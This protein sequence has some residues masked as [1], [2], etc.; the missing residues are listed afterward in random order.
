MR[1][2]NRILHNIL[3]KIL[4]F[5]SVTILSAHENVKM[6]QKIKGSLPAET[7]MAKQLFAKIMQ[8]N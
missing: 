7:Y 5:C 2:F 6:Q 3:D 1:Y 8:V 4:S